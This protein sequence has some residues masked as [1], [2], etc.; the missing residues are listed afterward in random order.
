MSMKQ[1]KLPIEGISNILVTLTEYNFWP[2]ESVLRISKTK[3]LSVQDSII[4]YTPK[5]DYTIIIEIDSHANTGSSESTVMIKIIT[6][7][8]ILVD[9]LQDP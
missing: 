9:N 5:I 2:I 4:I 6:L 3:I 7:T 8:Q 1:Y